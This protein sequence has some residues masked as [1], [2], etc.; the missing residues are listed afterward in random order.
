MSSGEI[1]SFKGFIIVTGQG[2]LERSG[3]GGGVIAGNVVV[4]PYVSSR[5]SD[6]SALQADFLAPQYDLSGGGNSTLAY[7]SQSWRKLKKLFAD[8]LKSDR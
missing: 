1:S 4:A 5:I 3:G 6:T 2:G 7:D 8:K